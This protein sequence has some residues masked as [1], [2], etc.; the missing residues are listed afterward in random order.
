VTA[1]PCRQ[2]VGVPQVA[3]RRP[4]IAAAFGQA[5]H[6]V[7][8]LRPALIRAA[9]RSSRLEH[10]GREFEVAQLECRLSDGVLGS[11]LSNDA[12]RQQRRRD[13]ASVDISRSRGAISD[14]LD[15]D[16]LLAQLVR[17]IGGERKAFRVMRVGDRGG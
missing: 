3:Q 11:P 2:A 10:G 9:G 5:A 14:R 15:V 1:S 12:R 8:N 13:S 16:K 7:C 17:F 6:P 4:Q